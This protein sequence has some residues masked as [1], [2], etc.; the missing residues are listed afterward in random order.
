M[1]M[2][3]DTR[4]LDFH[5]LGREIKRKREAKGWTQEYLAQLVDRTPRSIM[6]FENR[7][8]HPSLNT[9]YQIVTLLDISVDKFFYPDRQNS[10][11]Y[12]CQHIDVLLNSMNEKEFV[13]IEA[14]AGGIKKARETEIL[15]KSTYPFPRHRISTEK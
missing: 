14:T 13:V 3:Q 4:R 15:G 7:G 9:F 10:E 12:C 2:Y 5:A 11:S 8:Q 1:R 6:Y